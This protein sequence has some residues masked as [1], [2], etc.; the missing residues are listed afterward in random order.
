MGKAKQCH[1][2]GHKNTHPEVFS[3]EKKSELRK[4]RKI[5]IC[6]QEG[7]YV[8]MFVF[9]FV[10]NL[11]PLLFCLCKNVCSVGTLDI[12]FANL[13]LNVLNFC[14]ANLSMGKRPCNCYKPILQTKLKEKVQQF[15]SSHRNVGYLS[16][17]TTDAC[18]TFHTFKRLQKKPSQTHQTPTC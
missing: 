4:F 12:E 9:V 6:C 5:C 2:L 15:T 13:S 7:K 3:K 18:W 1:S 14:P 16:P 10:V 8:E 17:A 11:F